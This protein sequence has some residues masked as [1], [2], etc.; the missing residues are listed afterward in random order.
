MNEIQTLLD[1][2]RL[3]AEQHVPAESLPQIAWGGGFALLLGVG[4]SVLRWAKTAENATDYSVMNT[5]RAMLYLPT[6]PDDKYKA[7]LTLDTLVVRAGDMISALAVFV[8][9]EIIGA[10]PQG[11]GALNLLMIAA[12]GGLA[13]LLTREY[14]RLSSLGSS[15]IPA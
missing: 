10:T 4:L 7:K 11:F 1:Q 3:F 14:R 8:G 5:G 13:W 2:L 6:S 15:A 12:W 9:T